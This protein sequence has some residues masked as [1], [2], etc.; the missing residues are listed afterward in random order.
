MAKDPPVR[1]QPGIS[2]ICAGD[3]LRE[4]GSECGIEFDEEKTA[5]IDH[6]NF[7][8]SDLGQVIRPVTFQVSG[9]YSKAQA[10]NQEGTGRDALAWGPLFPTTCLPSALAAY[11]RRG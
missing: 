3:P 2:W 8:I 10:G 6:H 7:D 9:P 4:L 5:V 11:A 1:A